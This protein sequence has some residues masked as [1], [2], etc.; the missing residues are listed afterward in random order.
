MGTIYKE[1]HHENVIQGAASWE[2]YKRSNIMGNLYEEQ[3][4]GKLIQ[5]AASWEP[6]TRSRMWEK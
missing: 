4:H 1:Q 3:R 5:G 2:P 6:Y